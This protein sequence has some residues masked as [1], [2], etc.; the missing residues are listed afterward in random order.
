MVESDL[1]GSEQYKQKSCEAMSKRMMMVR[2]KE[3][4]LLPLSLH[5]MDIRRP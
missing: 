3:G 4:W 1:G 2:G 5:I